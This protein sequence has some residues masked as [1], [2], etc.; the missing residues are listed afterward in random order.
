M[1]QEYTQ[2]VIPGQLLAESSSSSSSTGE[3]SFINGHGT[4][5]VE[6]Q[7]GGGGGGDNNNPNTTTSTIQLRASI[8]GTVQRINKLISVQSIALYNYYT[9]PQVGDLIIGR[10]LSIQNG[11]WMIDISN[12]SSS[13]NNSSQQQSSMNQ[14]VTGILPL[15]GVHLP[16]S[17]QRVR[18]ANDILEMRQ[19]ICENDLV[20]CE[21]HKVNNQNHSNSIMLHTRS[22]RY[23]KLENGCMMMV[24]S[25]LITRMKTHYTTIID[26]RFQ[27]LLGCNGI[28]WIQRNNQSITTNNNS[29]VTPSMSS[30]ITTNNTSM[31]GQQ[32]LVEAEEIRRKVHSETP[33]TTQDRQD[34]AR[35]YNSIQC[36]LCTLSYITPD[37]I[38]TLYQRS[39]QYTITKNNISNMLLPESIVYLTQ[40]GEHQEPE[41]QTI[42]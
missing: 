17:I 35:I 34:L 10:V 13:S 22:I 40:Q 24:P 8:C 27:I 23:G 29:T 42:E 5:I 16:G 12:R 26:Q 11:K 37:T 3:D 9:Q 7:R 36:L 4:Y 21:V 39:L 18:T 6:H 32:E 20:S 15:S 19:Y 14:Y 25:K 1:I 38:T 30:D 31:I 28:I 33:Y 2:L 41:Q